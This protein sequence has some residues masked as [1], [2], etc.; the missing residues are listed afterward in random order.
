MI[1]SPLFFEILSCLSKCCAYLKAIV[2]F[3]KISST[4]KKEAE[5]LGVSCFSWEEFSQLGSLDCELHPKQKSDIC[6]IMYTSGT[7]GDPKGVF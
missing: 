3:R 4:Q 1:L 6:T 7:T 5:E 2:S